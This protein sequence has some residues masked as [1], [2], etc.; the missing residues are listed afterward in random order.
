MNDLDTLTIR[1]QANEI[2]ALK[3]TVAQLQAQAQV[4]EARIRELSAPAAETAFKPAAPVEIT[5]A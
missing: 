4:S 1:M 3:I 2:T 5:A